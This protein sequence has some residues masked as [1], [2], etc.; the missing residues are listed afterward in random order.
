MF[1]ML[2]SLLFLVVAA[3]GALGVHM[4]V[5]KA[6]QPLE[7]RLDA[8][9]QGS[10][11]AYSRSRRL[12][13]LTLA[14]FAQ[15]VA[16]S[17]VGA[18]L[19]VLSSERARMLDIEAKAYAAHPGAPEGGPAYDERKGWVS[20]Q[21][22]YLDAMSQ[23]LAE[24][25]ERRV[26]PSFWTTHP[27]DA[28]LEKFR[29]T[30]TA[31][32]ATAVS[33]CFFRLTFYPL[34]DVVRRLTNDDNKRSKPDMVVVTDDRGTGLADVD[35]PKWSDDTRFSERYPLIRKAREGV[36][37]RDVVQRD[38]G[39]SYYFV[40]AAPVM[41]AGSFSG[42]VLVGMEI[43]DG[44]IREEKAALGFE[45]SYLDGQKLVRSSLPKDEQQEILHN[46]PPRSEEAKVSFL[47]TEQMAAQF[48]PITGIY[49]AGDIKVVLSRLREP[50]QHVTS[51]IETYVWLYAVLMFLVVGGLLFWMRRAQTRP[52]VAL[53]SGLHE[54]MGGNQDYEFDS[55]S[56]DPLWKSFAG[57]LNRMV[58]LLRGGSIEED[59]LDAYLGVHHAGDP[60]EPGT[61]KG[62]G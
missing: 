18:Y 12:R 51:T 36:I 57:S 16:Q 19:D 31:C 47:D 3:V 2:L 23:K 32:S 26:G 29:D 49:S 11:Q 14:D 40:V 34:E 53:D 52:L 22:E 56:S 42:G 50:I 28:F 27:R 10:T 54:V 59:E 62:E 38:G 60:V 17:E 5:E 41:A 46:V 33:N 35:Q 61:D 21:T 30:L 25:I 55:G 8:E 44:F 58:G 6:A 1:H 37:A 4:G 15:G 39:N 24:R 20:A 7:Q 45:V 43:D 9:V 13:D 48:I